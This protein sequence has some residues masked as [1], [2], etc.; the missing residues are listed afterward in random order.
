MR[1]VY[2][3]ITNLVSPCGGILAKFQRYVGSDLNYYKTV[4]TVAPLKT[5]F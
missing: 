2:R 1:Y 3:K 4:D 5:R